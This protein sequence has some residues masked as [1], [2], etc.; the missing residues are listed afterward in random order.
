MK[1][2]NF[3][4][5]I[6]NMTL[7]DHIGISG[8]TKC[9]IFIINI[10]RITFI[11]GRKL[12]ERGCTHFNSNLYIIF[13]QIQILFIAW[14]YGRLRTTFYRLSMNHSQYLYKTTPSRSIF[15]VQELCELGIYIYKCPR[16]SWNDYDFQQFDKELLPKPT[17]QL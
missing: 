8:V 1:W 9:Q 7:R 16:D 14:S 3:D 17:H 2:L 5:E 4:I 12:L 11:K 15:R 10:S 6:K 13:P